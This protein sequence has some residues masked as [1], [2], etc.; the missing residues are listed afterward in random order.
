MRKGD[1]EFFKQE[2]ARMQK[3]GWGANAIRL[4]FN[5]TIVDKV[6]RG[7]MTLEEGKTHYAGIEGHPCFEGG[8]EY[9]RRVREYEAQGMTRSDAQG[10]VD[11]EDMY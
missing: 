10:A 6:S 4:V 7:Q 5:N 1:T 2:K 3:G 8:K 9:D 11:V